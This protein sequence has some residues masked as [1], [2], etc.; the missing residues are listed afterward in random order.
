MGEKINNITVYSTT[1]CGFCRSLKQ[2]LDQ[3]GIAYTAKDIEADESAYNELM[4]KLGGVDKFQGVPVTD[5]D[6]ELVTG[7]DRPKIDALLA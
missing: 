2:Y 4:E 5:I 1:W 3:K 6:G 7:F